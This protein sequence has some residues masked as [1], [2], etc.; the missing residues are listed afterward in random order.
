MITQTPVLLG[1]RQVRISLPSRKGLSIGTL[2]SCLKL[3]TS[4]ALKSLSF[5]EEALFEGS[6]THPS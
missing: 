3:S 1:A 4:I 2:L 6:P 5:S